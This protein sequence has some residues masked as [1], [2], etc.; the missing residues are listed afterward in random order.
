[1]RF[2]R[3]TLVAQVSPTEPPDDAAL[4]AALPVRDYVEVSPAGDRRRGETYRARLGY[5]AAV[6][7]AA[8]TGLA[9]L[10]L[11]PASVAS[12]VRTLSLPRQAA[13]PRPPVVASRAAGDGGSAV[14][15]RPA[16]TTAAA[17]PPS[18]TSAPATPQPTATLRPAQPVAATAVPATP[19]AAA[20]VAAAPA[21]ASPVVTPRAP[22]ASPT[23]LAT[24]ASRR[25]RMHTV[26]KGDTLFSIARNNGTTVDA[27]VTANALG[28]AAA[29]LPIGRQL[30]IPAG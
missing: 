19:V 23:A 12:H 17:P 2:S 14:A 10:T 21:A 30:V 26:E 8:A 15:T 16:L 7:L 1:M 6:A 29:V 3:I 4:D 27:L 11:F 25:E 28:S 13:Q 9:A 18:V 5:A 22:V 24:A 20:P